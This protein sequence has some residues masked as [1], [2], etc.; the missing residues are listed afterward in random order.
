MNEV[1]L[2]PAP[3]WFRSTAFACANDGTIAWLTKAII[4]ISKPRKDSKIR[5]FHFI[6]DTHANSAN[7]IAFS[8]EYGKPEK[9]FLV[10]GGSDNIKIWNLDTYETVLT[11]SY[12]NPTQTVIGVD[13]SKCDSNLICSVTMDGTLLTWNLN[14]NYCHKIPLGKVTASCLSCCPHQSN[15]VAVGLKLGLT[16]IVN[17]KGQGSISYKIRTSDMDITNISWCP[18][19]TNIFKDSSTDESQNHLLFAAGSKGKSISICR[20]SDGKFENQFTLPPNPL[21]SDHHRSK[22]GPK[23]ELF[24]IVCWLEPKI[25]LV[26]SLYGELLSLDIMQSMKKPNWRF[27]HG[28]H[29]RGIFTITQVPKLTV[30]DQ[31]NWRIPTKHR[32]WT[33]AQDRKIVCCTIENGHSEIDYCIPTHA[34]YIYSIEACPLETSLVAYGGGDAN[35]RLWN[36]SEPHD[37]KYHTTFF[38]QGIKAKVTKMAWHPE[39]ENI[40]AFGTGEGRV[41]ILDTNCSSKP[42]LLFRHHYCRTIYS[43]GWG[44]N[45][46]NDSYTIYASTGNEFFYYNYSKPDENPTVAAKNCTEFS[47][48]PSFKCL[49]LG[50]EDGTISF[51]NRK[52]EP[53]GKPIHLLKKSITRL[54]WHPESTTSDQD[55]SLMRNY[56]AVAIND[57]DITIFDMTPMIEQ[58]EKDTS[59]EVNTEND[60]KI[61]Y[62]IVGTLKGHVGSVY[63]LAWN[64]HITGQLVSGGFDRVAHVWRIDTLQL[65][66]SYAEHCGAVYS[67][68]WSPLNADYIMTGSGDHTLRVWKL[69]DQKIVIPVEHI[70]TNKNKKKKSKASKAIVLHQSSESFK[71]ETCEADS[72]LEEL[73]M[74]GHDN[75]IVTLQNNVNGKI[76]DEE[77]KEGNKEKKNKNKKSFLPLYRKKMNRTDVFL[78]SCLKLAKKVKEQGEIQETDPEFVSIFGNKS[79]ILTILSEEQSAYKEQNNYTAAVELSIWTNN[80]R[81][82][83]QD[84]AKERRLNDFMVSL[85]PMLSVKTWQEM[86]EAY[87]NQ[88]VIESNI[89]KAVNYFLCIHKIYRAIEVLTEAKMFREAYVLGKCKLDSQDAILNNILTEWGAHALQTGNYEDATQCYIILENFEKAAKILAKRKDSYFLGTAAILAKWS[90]NEELSQSIANEAVTESLRKNHPDRAEYFIQKLPSVRF[91][92]AHVETYKNIIKIRKINVPVSAWIGNELSHD[93]ITSLKTRFSELGL[94]DFSVY[95]KLNTIHYPNLPDNDE[96][97]WLII[98]HQI[99]L[100]ASA[101]SEEQQLRHIVSAC[102]IISQYEMISHFKTDELRISYLVRLLLVT[103]PNIYFFINPNESEV[104]NGLHKSLRAY[105]CFA[106]VQWLVDTLTKQQ[107]ES[108]DSIV[109][110]LV[111]E[112]IERCLEDAFDFEAIQYWT[113]PTE[114]TKL[115][116]MIAGIK[117][118]MQCTEDEKECDKTEEEVTDHD[119]LS[120]RLEKIRTERKKFIDERVTAPSPMMVYGKANELSNILQGQNIKTNLEKR[121]Q[122]L[123]NNNVSA[124]F[125]Y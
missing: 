1:V 66:A 71:I 124:M 45:P 111:I 22:L 112:I 90:N 48:H 98:S 32:V 28:V 61:G 114:M 101:P 63:C 2:P 40:L 88:L 86:C 41:G 82:Q 19:N 79:D 91:R 70:K 60:D 20:A 123:W 109:V 74:N 5:D 96:M 12:S 122:E 37:S 17:L 121:V 93:L 120:K 9:N 73:M 99:A 30:D 13:W 52:L 15:I 116:N 39:L 53:C 21:N 110:D 58:L 68:M 8:P 51:V 44:P 34:G 78:D 75:G 107:N 117:N 23:T 42:P 7:S 69:S 76:N 89:S 27:I 26:N 16:Y 46:L 115:E 83:L 102:G 47:W 25:L 55:L 56:L 59:S 18:T 10:S 118:D 119:E 49:A 67:C 24:T 104:N 113:A 31:D 72:T 36:L 54:I 106:I 95:S 64:P 80:L 77:K 50:F 38:W 65:I 94:N 87:G 125:T 6:L 35:I 14:V 97:L 43:L 92:L 84:A 33:T 4:T 105:F 3:N 103:F 62:R 85:A 57:P 11:Q 81:Q 100:A 108:E 29:Y